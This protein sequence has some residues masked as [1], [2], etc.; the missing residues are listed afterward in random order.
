MR[1]VNFFW[2]LRNDRVSI[3]L[4]A[5]EASAFTDK[6]ASSHYQGFK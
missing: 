5:Y 1:P 2:N 4:D 6:V 3:A